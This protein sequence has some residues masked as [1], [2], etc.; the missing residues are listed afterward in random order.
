MI[1]VI[2]KKLKLKNLY[3]ASALVTLFASC[4]SNSQTTTVQTI[5]K[6][7]SDSSKLEVPTVVI[8]MN[9]DNYAE[10]DPSL[11]HDKIF[12]MQHNSVNRW[13]GDATAGRVSI[14]PVAESDG[15]AD[16]GVISVSMGSDRIDRS[17]DSGFDYDTKS[18]RDIDITK[19]ITSDSVNDAI[20]FSLYDR[21]QNGIIEYSELQIIFIVAGGEMAYG[22]REDSLW[23]HSWNYED[24]SVDA[25]VVDGVKLMYFSGDLKTSGSYAAFGATHSLG[26]ND[27]HK[28]TIG[29][30]AHEMGHAMLNLIDLYDISYE[31]S[32]VGY[33][34]IMGGG[35]WAQ[36]EINEYAGESPTQ[37]SAY[38]KLE[39]YPS[40]KSI[41]SSIATSITLKCSEDEMIKLTT[42]RENEYFLVGCRDTRRAIS[43]AGFM[44]ADS[45]FTTDRLFGVL[46][47]IDSTKETNEEGGSQTY[48]NHYRV[49]VVQKSYKETMATSQIKANFE[50]VFVVGDTMDSRHT[51]LYDGAYSNYT[52]HIDTQDNES[53]T[54]TFTIKH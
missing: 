17:L 19:A 37:F 6:I 34:D 32:G 23:A 40:T 21:D 31:G 13:Y 25:P 18:F 1:S 53:R 20:D 14:V 22:D 48:F 43:D 7:V 38:N 27:E 30:I 54:M 29:I 39:V 46:Y 3:L 2:M 26:N 9:W 15:V 52:L 11:W 51:M 50:D 44:S 47:H 28:A 42:F 33:F 8:L 49:A 12:D 36:S 16:D 4:G 10:N 24:S 35:T 5:E 45:R 41:E